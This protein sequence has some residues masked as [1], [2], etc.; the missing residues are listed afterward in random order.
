MSL[1]HQ[2]AD[3]SFIVL[4]VAFNTSGDLLMARTMRKVGDVDVIR[5]Q[6]GIV[7]V[8]RAIL[9]TPSFY[10]ALACMAAAFFSLLTALSLIDLSLVI[11][12]A[13]SLTF[14]SNLTGAKFFLKERVD[15]TRWIAGLVVMCG[16]VLLAVKK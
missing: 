4:L 6:R 10:G 12:A 13:A 11:P 5:K 14:L 9:T 15:R 1:Q 16:V 7:G 2:L 8:V 3:A